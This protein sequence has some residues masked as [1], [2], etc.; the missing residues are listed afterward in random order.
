VKTSLP[1][2]LP[3]TLLGVA[4]ATVLAAPQP[5]AQCVP[6]EL[7][8]VTASSGFVR[9]TFGSS[10]ARSGDTMIVGAPQ[11][12]RAYVFERVQGAW[13]EA[14]EL[15]GAG[16]QFGAAVVL[17]GDTAVVGAPETGA[18][19]AWVFDRNTGGSGAWGL[20]R[21]LQPELGTSGDAFGS[22]LALDGDTLL[23]AAVQATRT[24]IWS[25]TVYVFD[26]NPGGTPWVQ[27]D[28]IVPQSTTSFAQFGGA[29]A[30]QGDE[31]FIGAPG[32][33]GVGTYAGRVQ[34]YSR[35]GGSWTH[36]RTLQGSAT[37]D[38][39]LFGCSVDV[40]G[41]ELAAGALNEW[42]GSVYVFE[43]DLGGSGNWGEGARLRPPT[44][45][46]AYGTWVDLDGDL[47]AIG[48]PTR[49]N[50]YL[51]GRVYLAGRDFFPA[52]WGLMNRFKATDTN[53][54]D[55]FGTSFTLQDGELV[56]GAT[57]DQGLNATLGAVYY[58]D[59]LVEFPHPYCTAGKT[60]NGC[61]AKICG[62]GTPS[63]S[64][65]SGF[66]VTAN[67]VEG[68]RNGL[69]FFGANGQQGVVWGGG[70]SFQCVVPPVLRGELISSGGTGG[71]CSGTFTTD[72]NAQWAAHPAQ[73]PGVGAVVQ[74]QL[75]FR[76]PQNSSGQT[77]SLSDALQFTVAP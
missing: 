27:A 40:Q 64:A 53:N 22:T 5:R 45:G 21:Q 34:V 56:V 65:A 10:V 28:E 7:T 68:D 20:V 73:N 14:A 31:A 54:K 30:L 2:T 1:R 49:G 72:L 9:D 69:F 26:R 11:A 3:R 66:A 75:W 59:G 4:V 6:Q 39:A 41:D 17:R 76:D 42:G 23:V 67:D 37:P 36:V 25:G 50:P 38:N 70:S 60:S 24:A 74:L 44:N 51:S 8:E 35:T 29:L 43:R 46:G 58:F 32:T 48:A 18:G 16:G 55:F 62:Y 71:S 63:A 13:I 77:T 47:L 19:Q 57:R 61:A 33:L 12:D 52:P 15:S